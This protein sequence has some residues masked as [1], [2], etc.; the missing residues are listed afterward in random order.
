MQEP[1][2]GAAGARRALHQLHASSRDGGQP[3]GGVAGTGRTH[4][5]VARAVRHDDLSGLARPMA[6]RGEKTDQ[7]RVVRERRD[8]D[9]DV[10][11]CR[12]DRE[13]A[14]TPGVGRHSPAALYGNDQTFGALSGSEVHRPGE[15]R[16]VRTTLIAILFLAATVAAVRLRRQIDDPNHTDNPR[17]AS[18][19]TPTKWRQWTGSARQRRRGP[20][21]QSAGQAGALV[22][23]S[24]HDSSRAPRVGFRAAGAKQCEAW[25]QFC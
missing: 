4:C 22:P 23:G 8:H 16:N 11:R 12:H 19:S 9:A 3:T 20:L 14:R 7:R 17:S 25:P 10:I 13:R 24:A 5:V 2:H 15:D 1:Q 21:G 6:D 18:W